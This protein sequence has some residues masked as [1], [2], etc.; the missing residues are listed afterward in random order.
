MD[1]VNYK[2]KILSC[3]T[4][5]STADLPWLF[6]VSSGVVKKNTGSET[7]LHRGWVD[8]PFAPPPELTVMVFF[9]KFCPLS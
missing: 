7:V 3:Y 1:C 6:F 5:K 2:I 4:H 8:I 9:L